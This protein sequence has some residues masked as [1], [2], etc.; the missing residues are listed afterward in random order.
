MLVALLLLLVAA[1]ASITGPETAARVAGSAWFSAAGA[2]TAAALL[3]AAVSAVRRRPSG[4]PAALL[5]HLGLLVGLGGIILNQSAARSGYLFLESG[6]GAKDF[7]LDRGLRRLATLPFPVRLD[8]ITES[9]ARGFLPAPVTWLTAG[10]R[11]V[12]VSY[13]R[14]LRRCGWKFVFGRLTGPGFPHEYEVTAG[15]ETWLLLHNQQARLGPGMVLASFGYDAASGSLGLALGTQQAWL[16]PGESADLA[17]YPLRLEAVAFAN[18]P[19]AV[20][21]VQD[22]RLRPPLFAGFGLALAGALVL[23]LRRREP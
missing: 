11:S 9:T 5:A 23:L 19:G 10:V 15:S 16:R 2:A 6:A 1:I 21:A 7:V 8:S 4:W 20:F 13:N 18:G 22:E 12:P 3:F 17:G 14:A